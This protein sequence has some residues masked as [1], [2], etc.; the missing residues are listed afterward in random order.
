MFNAKSRHYQIQEQGQPSPNA[1]SMTMHLKRLISRYRNK[2][3]VRAEFKNFT[4]GEKD[5]IQELSRKITSMGVIANATVQAKMGDNMKREQFINRL[6]EQ[7][8]KELLLRE[9]HDIFFNKKQ[10]LWTKICQNGKIN[11]VYPSRVS[12]STIALI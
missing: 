6:S 3:T 8:I 2:R 5:G 12:A 4:Q 10:S 11:L 7:E 9:D 1:A